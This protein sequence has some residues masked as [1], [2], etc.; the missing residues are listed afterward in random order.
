MEKDFQIEQLKIENLKLKADIEKLHNREGLYKRLF[1]ASPDIIIEVDSNRII[2]ICHIP[3]YSK[4]ILTG[5]IG[6]NIFD[7]TP[8][9]FHTQMKMAL[10]KVFYSGEIATYNSEGETIGAY[11][12]Y[13][14]HLSPIYNENKEI[15]SAY[16]ISRE[17]TQQKIAEQLIIES[18]KKLKAIFDSSKHLH[19]LLGTDACCLWFNKKANL[20][21]EILFGKKLEIGKFDKDYIPEERITSFRLFFQKCLTSL[22][23]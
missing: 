11:R 2:I 15:T 6:K 19:I 20:A 9:V 22:T 7:V 4:E 13:S 10:D 5:L 17:V 3:N 8:V 23:A 18:E 14:N 1:E 12:Y 21:T 16:F